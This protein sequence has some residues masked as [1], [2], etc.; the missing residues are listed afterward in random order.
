[1]WCGK[2]T[3]LLMTP[4]WE[5]DQDTVAGE[6]RQNE[7]Q[8][9]RSSW[10]LGAKEGKLL[11]AIPTRLDFHHACNQISHRHDDSCRPF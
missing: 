6:G 2:I 9:G 3:S 5:Q 11:K 7:Y 8:L 1:M 4:V 10:E